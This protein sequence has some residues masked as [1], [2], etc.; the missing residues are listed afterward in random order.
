LARILVAEDDADIRHIVAQ[1]LLDEGHEVA[2][3]GDGG[4]AVDRLLADPPDI[5]IL[6]VMMPELDGYSVL[7][8]L[9]DAGVD[10]AIKVLV[11]SARGTERDFERSFALGACRHMTKPFDPDEL[12]ESV[13]ELLS[14]TRDELVQRRDEERQRAH[15]LSQLESIFSED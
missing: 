2:T 13:N 1:L 14:M 4:L 9:R 8:E 12:V 7:E 3:V 6:D 10:S 5:L 15:L 11:L